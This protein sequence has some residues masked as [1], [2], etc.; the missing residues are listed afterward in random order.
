VGV[1]GSPAAA[2]T[3]VCVGGPHCYATVQAAVDAAQNGETIRIAPG[4]YA[5]GIV[6][7]KSVDLVGAG[8]NAT[9]I[10]GGGPVVTIGSKTSSPTVSITGVTVT[11]GMTTTNPQAPK[12]GPDVPTCGPGYADATAL[13]GGIETFP[14]TTVT[15]V[16]SVIA[17]NTASPAVATNSV[18]AVCPGP[19]PCPASYG[20][21]AGIDNWG[22]M[23]LVGTTVSDNHASA[24]QSNGGGIVSEKHTSLTL[25]DSRVV[26]NSANAAGPFGRFVS[27]GG[28]LVDHFVTLTIENS[29]ID[30]NSANLTSSIPHPYPLQDGG[31][32][33]SNAF[34]GGIQLADD[35][36]ATIRNSTLDGNS[37]TVNSP[38]GEPFGADAAICACGT[39]T[40]TLENAAVNGNSVD[41]N[42]LDTAASGP[43]GPSALEF[44][45]PGTARNVRITGNSTHVTASSGDAGALGALAIFLDSSLS[46]AIENASISDNTATATAPN[47]AATIQGV[48]VTNN[49]PLVLTN[50]GVDRNHGTAT[51]ASGFAQGGG[52]W[53][54]ELFAGPTSSLTLENSH[55]VGNV[56]SGS[57]GVAL[58]GGGIFSLGFPV[59]LDH[60]RVANNTPDDCFGC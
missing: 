15:I 16:R 53:N 21:A 27:G 32:D 60:S 19:A 35:V 37:I 55:V 34:G 56:L 29:N 41:V 4:T 44:D 17:R 38:A 59:T 45:S 36:T 52:I 39:A 26:G 1:V 50:V 54:N 7:E 13:G 11:G 2:A 8:A 43:S 57:S 3:G 48:G 6:V 12:C 5:G 31:T 51:G 47:G 18:K 25:L 14:G 46:Q 22:T 33:Q 28:I 20:D 24:V 42:V 40:L 58:Q 49:G 30:R 10:S 23:T 9:V